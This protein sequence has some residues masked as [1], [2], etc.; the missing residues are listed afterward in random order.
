MSDSE[1]QLACPVCNADTGEITFEN[2]QKAREST[3]EYVECR[4]CS[5]GWNEFNHDPGVVV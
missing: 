1:Y 5:W 3:P 4:H 2:P